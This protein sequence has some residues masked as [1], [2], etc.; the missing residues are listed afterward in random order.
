MNVAIWLEEHRKNNI[1]FQT[2]MLA[3]K[4]KERPLPYAFVSYA[5]KDSYLVKNIVADFEKKGLPFWFDNREL[6][7]NSHKNYNDEINEGLRGAF[8]VIIFMSKNYWDSAYC[9]LEL[10]TALDFR[11]KSTVRRKYDFFQSHGNILFVDLDG[12]QETT[13]DKQQLIER[14]M[15]KAGDLTIINFNP[16]ITDPEKLIQ[17]IVEDLFHNYILK[18]IVKVNKTKDTSVVP[19]VPDFFSRLKEVCE[20]N[21]SHEEWVPE[22]SLR[23][24]NSDEEEA[25]TQLIEYLKQ[26]ENQPNVFIYG[27]GGGG[28]TVTLKYFTRYLLEKNIPAIYVNVNQLQFEDPFALW[29]YI[30]NIVCG[31]AWQNAMR[32]YMRAVPN[33]TNSV[34]LLVDGINEI[35]EKYR[36]NFV[37]NCINKFSFENVK[38]ILTSRDKFNRELLSA[39]FDTIKAIPPDEET[40]D[41]YLQTRGIHVTNTIK[42]ILRTPMMLKIFT[43]T[44]KNKRAER[45]RLNEHPENCGQILE[46]FFQLQIHKSGDPTQNKILFQYLLPE[47]ALIMVKNDS[48]IISTTEIWTLIDDIKKNTTNAGK[49]FEFYKRTFPPGRFPSINIETLFPLAEDMF[50][51]LS[52]TDKENKINEN[53]EFSH[54]LW[55]DFFCACSIIFEMFFASKTARENDKSAILTAMPFPEDVLTLVADLTRESTNT[56]FQRGAGQ[57]WTFPS[58]DFDTNRF[59][60][61]EKLLQHWRGKE[62]TSAQNAVFNL[63]TIMRLGRK[64]NLSH[65]NLSGLDLRLC[66]MNGCKFVEFWRGNIY[67]SNFDNSWVTLDFFVNDGHSSQITAVC[68]DG[69]NF[70]F[71][72]DSSGEVRC[73]DIETED[74]ILIENFSIGEA[75]VDL[76]WNRGNL[77]ILYAN[78]LILYPTEKLSSVIEYPNKHK[79]KSFRYVRFSSCGSLEVS[80]NIEPLIFFAVEDEKLVTCNMDYDV[81]AHCAVWNPKSQQIV[82]SYLLRLIEVD[83][84]DQKKQRWCRHPS[85][86]KD[87]K[88][89][90]NDPTPYDSP[91]YINLKKYGVNKNDLRTECICFNAAGTRFLIATGF[92]LLEFD[93]AS[94]QLLRTKKFHAK[95]GACCY[96]EKNKIF[97]GVGNNLKILDHEFNEVLTMTGAKFSP[98]TSY[99]R[100]PNENC[101]YVLSSNG[102][103][104]QIDAN[105]AH[106]RRIR[107]V[108][109]I[110]KLHWLKD[111]RTGEYE[112]LLLPSKNFPEGRRFNFK[113]NLEQELGW[114][115]DTVDP[116][117]KNPD[118]EDTVLYEIG[119]D[120]CEIMLVKKNADEN[121]K[122]ITMKN[123]TG[124]FIFGCSFRK[125][126]GG[127]SE[128]LKKFLKF[129]GGMSD[130]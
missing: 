95:I 68:T 128:T 83:Y 25:P 13:L 12:W 31:N 108:K 44:E 60:Y 7:K 84:F 102:E 97:A 24:K 112:L 129:N 8:C 111:K 107:Q 35:P 110:R 93:S 33:G 39:D 11:S 79:S 113:T 58:C 122:R 117:N 103:I 91:G 3:R 53:Y 123:F 16:S 19:D 78:R 75:V 9:P 69:T 47:L 50:G 20:K 80:F 32:M 55:R 4:I 130:E 42:K 115:Y 51:L 121:D 90:S 94:L 37:S 77:A 22:L 15:E 59:P 41:H 105:D 27:E 76:A 40:I 106:V 23:V 101:F 120:N 34:V 14:L 28:K 98:V 100:S 96:A 99:L 125:L 66:K 71:S 57:D 124:V 126:R 48:M 67:P 65:L 30:E 127:S 109:E 49:R 54:Q 70:I 61:A 38:F 85:L 86:F 2:W 116:I 26:L 72:G 119:E 81:P 87:P 73:F 62:G 29:S 45:F 5:H 17:K 10:E 64:N 82:R 18:W 36:R 46:N 21:F 118:V 56:P 104:K 92:L 43:D 63:L 89:T 74:W 1:D 6:L 52:N 114:C 88:Q